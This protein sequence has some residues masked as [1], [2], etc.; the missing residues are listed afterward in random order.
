MSAMDHAMVF[1]H[2]RHNAGRIDPRIFGGFLEHLGRAVYQ[3]VYDPG[4]PLS[5]E[6]GFRKDVLE[7]LRRMRMPLV[8][9]PGGNFVSDYNWTDG[10]GPRERRPKRAD[11]AWRSLEPNEFGT[12]EF[13][14]WCRALGTA[15]MIAVNLGTGTAKAAAELVEYCNLGASTYWSDLRAQNGHPSPHA[16]PVWCLGNEMDGPWQA[17]HVP[18]RE[19]AQRARQAAALMKGIDP[20][21]ELVLAGS[22]GRQMPTYLAWDREALEHCWDQVE[23]ISAHRYSR[24]ERSDTP[25]FLAE[26]V[27]IERILQDYRGLLGYMRG[28]RRSNKNVYVAFDEWNVWYR[29]RAVRDGGWQRAPS[30]IEEVYNLEDALVCAQYLNAFIR[31]ADIVKIACIAQIV[32]VIAPLI[33]RRDGLLIQSIYWPFVQYAEHATGLALSPLVECATYEAGERGQ[34]PVIDVSAAYDQDSGALSVFAVNR[35]QDGELELQVRLGERRFVHVQEASALTGATPQS[36]NTWE[37]PD[38]VRPGKTKAS[39]TGDGTFA[40][41]TMPPLSSCVL[42]LLTA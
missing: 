41:L 42:K 16:V 1:L 18:A 27:E 30:L 36:Q 33:T 29:T 19:Y 15:P 4:N 6:R 26:G 9:Y 31:N 23:Y 25:W 39:I 11:F 5:D 3:G 8:R 7:A 12:D 2:P 17:G 38:S 40:T 34:V 20:S 28:V 21:I 10:I 32:N 37:S 35:R 14:E 24:N 13:V 22:S